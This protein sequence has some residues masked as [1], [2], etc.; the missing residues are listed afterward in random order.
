L[1]PHF[2]TGGLT[3]PNYFST[4]G[5]KI[6]DADGQEVRLTGINWFGMETGTY[7]PHGLWIRNWETMLDWIAALGY[8]TIRLPF[9][10]EMFEPTSRPNGIDWKANPDLKGLTGIQVMDRIIAGAGERGLK[11]ILDRHRPSSEA[12]AKLWYTAKCSEDRWIADWKMLAQRYLGND[13]VIGADLHNEPAGDATWGTGDLKTDWRLAAERA[14]NAILSVNPHWLIIVEGIEKRGNQWFWMGGDLSGVAEA[15]VRLTVP[16]KLVYSAHDYGPGVF[17][18][19]WFNDPA[20]PANLPQVWDKHWGYIAKQGI[21]P[22][23]LGEFGGKSVGV[24]KEGVWQRSLLD[25]LKKNGISYTYWAI[26]PNSGD[27]GG[28]LLDD[29]LTV[30]KEKQAMLSAYQAT[31][32]SSV[33]PTKVDQTFS[34]PPPAPTLFADVKV[35]YRAINTEERTSTPTMELQVANLYQ[36]QL[37]LSDLELR[38]WFTAANTANAT[39]TVEV[40]RATVG[41]PDYSIGINGDQITAKVVAQVPA[42]GKQTHYISLTFGPQAGSMVPEH[43]FARLTVRLRSSDGATYVQSDDYSYAPSKDLAESLKIG[44][45]EKGKLV[46]GQEPK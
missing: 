10:N 41:S 18:Q 9:G 45:Y 44:L 1:P 25:Y 24:D 22:V 15:P 21:A 4:S 19:G 39:R 33:N 40:E 35:Y 27:T 29:W 12:Q 37:P 38:Y 43:G 3:K 46:W 20:F 17:N 8:N 11:V 13:V 16:N 6:V 26:N 28:L 30:N 42:A 34:P 31:K 32:L 2:A 7:A 23:L 14:G 36:R 5:S